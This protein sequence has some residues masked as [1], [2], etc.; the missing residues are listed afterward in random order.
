MANRLVA[1]H[2]KIIVRRP[3][4]LGSMAGQG[5]VTLSARLCFDDIG[6]FSD[7]KNETQ[8]TECRKRL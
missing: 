8:S 1:R 5:Q 4:L 3:T 7:K 6:A 2:L